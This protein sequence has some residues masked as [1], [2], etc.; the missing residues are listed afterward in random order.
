MQFYLRDCKAMW[1]RQ[2]RSLLPIESENVHRYTN[3]YNR[4]RQTSH[5]T[6]WHCITSSLRKLFSLQ[7]SSYDTDCDD[8]VWQLTV[9]N[10][11]RLAEDAHLK[12]AYN[13]F[14]CK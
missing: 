6:Q 4:T 14:Q 3:E 7:T 13:K 9:W 1:F 11:I 10:V 5:N 2:H 8:N 12:Q